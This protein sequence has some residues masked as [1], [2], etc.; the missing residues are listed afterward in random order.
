M[1]IAMQCSSLFHLLISIAMAILTARACKGYSHAEMY[2]R[3]LTIT[4]A[5][6]AW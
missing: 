1:Q 2:A 3:E 6:I 4:S 5:A